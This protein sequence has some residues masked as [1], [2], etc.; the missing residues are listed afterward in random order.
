MHERE[1]DDGEVYRL[2]NIP[3]G[4]IVNKIQGDG[5]WHLMSSMQHNEDVQ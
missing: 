2:L 3:L 1:I 5:V 4:N